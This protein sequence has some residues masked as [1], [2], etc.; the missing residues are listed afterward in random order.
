VIVIGG[1]R[2]WRLHPVLRGA[3]AY[4]VASLVTYGFVYYGQFRYRLAMEPLMILV[5]TPLLVTVW[6]Q[7]AA[8][9]PGPV[10]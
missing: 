6:Q 5:A 3:L 10:D 2:L 8:L 7:R 9:R 1:R 4:L